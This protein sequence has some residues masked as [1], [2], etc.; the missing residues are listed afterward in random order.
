ME[1]IAKKDINNL[2][3]GILGISVAKAY[4]LTQGRINND[5]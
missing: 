3:L 5:F 1:K 4:K 2:L